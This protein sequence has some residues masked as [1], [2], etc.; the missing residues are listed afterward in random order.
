MASPC[1]DVQR[2]D[3]GTGQ[4]GWALFDSC[5]SH[6]PS[7]AHPGQGWSPPRRSPAHQL[8]ARSPCAA[9]PK[10]HG[11]SVAPGTDSARTVV[12]EEG[13]WLA[14]RRRGCAALATGRGPA[15]RSAWL[16]GE[17]LTPQPWRPRRPH[18]SRHGCLGPRAANLPQF[19]VGCGSRKLPGA[20]VRCERRE[21]ECRQ[22][23]RTRRHCDQMS[24]A[25][26]GIAPCCE[27]QVGTRCWGL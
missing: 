10:I 16:S 13:R 12:Q 6:S 3:L 20:G 23:P 2:G 24:S 5:T 22:R 21:L 27:A 4:T 25:V 19:S 14:A 11:L 1:T 17:E 15:L 8:S 7:A 26:L 18:I 9:R